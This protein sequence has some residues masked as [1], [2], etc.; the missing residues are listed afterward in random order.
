MTKFEWPAWRILAQYRQGDAPASG[1]PLLQED[2]RMETVG[3]Y[4]GEPAAPAPG[5]LEGVSGVASAKSLS[6]S[7]PHFLFCE[8]KKIESPRINCF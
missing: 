4:R 2:Q 3:W 7:E 5:Q 1:F 8:A 6:T